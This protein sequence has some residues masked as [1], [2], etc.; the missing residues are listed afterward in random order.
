[1][2]VHLKPLKATAWRFQVRKRE[3]KLTPT[4]GVQNCQEVGQISPIHFL[5]LIL[6]IN[7]FKLK[8]SGQPSTRT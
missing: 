6:K 7:L 4:L 1:M 5:L 8:R 3:T 2:T